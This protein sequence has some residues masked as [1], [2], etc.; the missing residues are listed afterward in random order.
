M[1]LGGST[2]TH[3][4]IIQWEEKFGNSTKEMA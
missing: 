1:G 4:S 3:Y 2:R